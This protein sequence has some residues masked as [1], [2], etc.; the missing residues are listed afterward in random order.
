M[1]L[2][3]EFGRD[4][5]HRLLREHV[6]GSLRVGDRIEWV[7]KLCHLLALLL[8]ADPGSSLLLRQRVL[9]TEV[10]RRPRLQYLRLLL[11]Q[12]DLLTL[13]VLIRCQGDFF[14]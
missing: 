14:L 8:G 6:L 12:T 11:N 13:P 9:A 4:V 5:R 7:L 3:V 1:N 2:R 10:D